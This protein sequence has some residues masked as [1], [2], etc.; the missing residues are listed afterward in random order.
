[1]TASRHHLSRRT[2]LGPRLEVDLA[3]TRY[4]REAGRATL[5]IG[6]VMPTSRWF[7]VGSADRSAREADAVAADDTLAHDNPELFVGG[8]GG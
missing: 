6:A 1:M 5:K 8:V 7:A 3:Q 2:L 4:V